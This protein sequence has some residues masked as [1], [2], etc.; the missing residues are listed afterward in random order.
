MTRKAYEQVRVGEQM[1]DSPV[2]V[3]GQNRTS[4]SAA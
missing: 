1:T 2:V 3:V 4:D